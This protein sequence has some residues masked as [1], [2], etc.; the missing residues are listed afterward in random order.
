MA[1]LIERREFLKCAGASF[2]ASLPIG[3]REALA[4]TSAVYASA[5]IENDNSFSLALLN[6]SGEI[7]HKI[8]LPARGHDVAYSHTTSRAVIF[9]R[10]PGTFAVAFDRKGHRE[11][12][13]FSSP[14]GRHF[15]GHG[16]FS[17]DGKLLYATENDFEN[18][19]GA[20]GIYSARD[21][22]RRVGELPSFGTGPHEIELMPDGQTLCVANGGI[23]THP[24]YGRAKLNISTMKPSI[25]FVDRINGV[26]IEQQ[27]LPDNLHQLS[28]RHMAVGAGGEVVF[29]CQ[30]QGACTDLPPLAGKSKIG[31]NIQLWNWPQQDRRNLANYIGSVAMSND[32]TQ[33]AISS[34]KGNAVMI[35][36]T[37][38]GEIEKRV[39]C[40]K[41]GGLS[42]N[43][44]GFNLTS[45]LG[46]FG[47]VDDFPQ[48][49]QSSTYFDNHLSAL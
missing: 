43:S 2:I 42:S 22:F 14:N 26:L 12:V 48:S 33:A 35:I 17:P 32:Q 21:D 10:R 34:P 1:P 16:V 38:T 27:S 40:S 36:S 20:I 9:A 5:I 39:T 47:S 45:K 41:A 28:I 31:E 11:P 25:C 23:E 6:Q 15:Y 49:P 37:K 8:E 3:T 46:H 44:S 30:Y 18:A 24:I 19:A 4:Q 13:T 29:G 7:F